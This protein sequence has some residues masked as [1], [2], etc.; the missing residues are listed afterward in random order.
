LLEGKSVEAGGQPVQ[1]QDD[2]L[3]RVGSRE[4]WAKE[5]SYR[6]LRQNIP[7]IGKANK[8]DKN[9]IHFFLVIS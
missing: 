7:S 1:F 5:D 6:S 3:H 9:L 4:S 2:P 8:R